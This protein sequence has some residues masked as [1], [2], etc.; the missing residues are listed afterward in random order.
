MRVLRVIV[1]QVMK[2]CDISFPWEYSMHSGDACCMSPTPTSTRKV[3]KCWW[4]GGGPCI[5]HVLALSHNSNDIQH[6]IDG[7]LGCYWKAN[8]R[9]ICASGFHRMTDVGDQPTYS[10]LTSLHNCYM[11]SDGSDTF[12]SK[13]SGKKTSWGNKN[14][15]IISP[16][17]KIKEWHYP[18]ELRRFLSTV[19]IQLDWWVRTQGSGRDKARQPMWNMHIEVPWAILTILG[20]LW[21]H[22]INGTGQ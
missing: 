15:G 22:M 19:Q 6:W 2:W 8:S 11:W 12:W 9:S 10:F 21:P 20:R 16:I 4:V 1:A 14:S 7:Q 3:Y 17:T 13:V 18:C 5:C